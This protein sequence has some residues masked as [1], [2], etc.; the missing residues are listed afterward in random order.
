MNRAGWCQSRVE[1]DLAERA[2]VANDVLLEKSQQGLGLLRAEINALKV[3][4]LDLGF[5]LL[6]KSAE[7]EK[8][9]PDIHTHLHTI[10]VRLPIV[11]AVGQLDV[12]L[13]WKA[14]RNAV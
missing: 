3:A 4:N 10:G 12:R 2:F 11:G 5:G 1:F 6:L 13:C 8:E 14:H 9:V 7:D